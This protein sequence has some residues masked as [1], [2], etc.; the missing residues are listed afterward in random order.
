MGCC[1]ALGDFSLEH[2]CHGLPKGRP[3]FAADP[4]GEKRRGH[5]VGQVRCDFYRIFAY[6][7]A[8]IFQGRNVVDLQCITLNNC[9]SS[10]HGFRNIVQRGKAPL[11]ALDCHDMLG[12]GSEKGAGQSA[13][14]RPNLQNRH[15]IKIARSTGNFHRDVEV[16]EEILPERL[17]GRQAMLFDHITE[18][19]QFINVTHDAFAMCFAISAAMRNAAIVLAGLALPVPAISNAVPWSGEVRMKGRPSVTFTLSSKPRALAGMSA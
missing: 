14:T 17:F 19:W 3:V 11:V 13:G 16:E 10:G 2:Q 8:R 7:N 15:A 1:N 9:Q 4:A 5:V 12:A 6:L 18:W